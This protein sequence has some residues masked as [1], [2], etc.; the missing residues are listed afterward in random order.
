[1]GRL[2]YGWIMV[3]T[4]ALTEAIS[5]G[6]LYFSFSVFV[7]PMA[8]E[9]GWSRT[10]IASGFS[11]AMLTSAF[12][13]IPIGWWL[14][15]H[16]PRW[17]MTVGSA[18][19]TLLLL[20]W[21]T[22][23]DPLV[24]LGIWVL[25]GLAMA[26]VFFEPA[27][28]VTALWFQRRRSLAITILSTCVGFASVIFAPLAGA[29]VATIGWRSALMALAAIVGV[30]TV[31]PHAF[32][33]RHRPQDL[34]LAPDGGTLVDRSVDQS[35]ELTSAQ[36]IDATVALR[37]VVF[38]WL[39]LAFAAAFFASNA[40]TV[41]LVALLVD[42]QFDQA[43]AVVVAGAIGLMAL[44]GRFGFTLLG[45]VAPRRWVLG[46]IFACQAVGLL[47]LALA[48]GWTGVVSFVVLFG[49][50]FGAL[51]SGRAALLAE[52]FG[53]EYFGRLNG[54]QSMLVTFARAAGPSAAGLAYDIFAQYDQAMVGAGLLS[55]AAAAAM[56]LAPRNWTER[57]T[58]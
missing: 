43:T 55:L 1:M 17:L 51:T 34:G 38:W 44:P 3:W 4:L 16:G 11:I 21:S 39:T 54:V 52:T 33:L 28:Q 48:P 50:G 45:D 32:I 53:A 2:Y 14:D 8:Q 41:H 56:F 29:M 19:A 12:A 42:R 18:S 31:L 27:F 46:S 22:V 20:L 13:A 26:M 10:L 36:A 15:R 57:V 5:W 7:T 35:I 37:S 58:G 30:G 24:F 40:A 25:M 49:V 47:M 23:S 6:A 9:F